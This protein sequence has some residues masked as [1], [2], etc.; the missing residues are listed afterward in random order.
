MRSL[1]TM[2]AT[3]WWIMAFSSGLFG[4]GF[5][6]K[7]ADYLRMLKAKQAMG[8]Q[9]MPMAQNAPRATR[10]D[11]PAFADPAA[12]L[13]ID[14]YQPTAM[15]PQADLKQMV[16]PP[17]SRGLFGAGWDRRLAD[18]LVAFGAG[19]AGGDP[20]AYMDRARQR[21]RNR[22]LEDWARTQKDPLAQVDPEAAFEQQM[23]L[24]RARQAGILSNE[25]AIALARERAR[26]EEPEFDIDPAT[27]RPYTI[28]GGRI[29]FGEGNITPRPQRDRETSRAPPAGYRWTADG[30]L[31][32]IRGGPADL[33][34]TESG[35]RRAAAMQDSADNLANVIASIDEALPMVSEATTGVWSTR[36]GEWGLNQANVDLQAAIDPIKAN[37]GFEALAEMRR[38]SETGGALGQVA[39]QELAMLQ[40]VLRNLETSQS[41]AQLSRNL[42]TTRAQVVRTRQAVLAARAEM[43]AGGREP[44]QQPAGDIPVIELEP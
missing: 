10:M 23:M 5:N 38:N 4:S 27:G 44:A 7:Q 26:F 14:A 1:S 34:A 15:D 35:A 19:I 32:V 2:T 22:R 24:E 31:E 21:D 16:A 39:V 29:Q 12:P 17:R 20:M 41:G 43:M 25:Q 11:A 37:L 3:T 30:N 18:A 28:R 8:G 42:A 33:R 13:M 36:L 40:R 9:K 6:A